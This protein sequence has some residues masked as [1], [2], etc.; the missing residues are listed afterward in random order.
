MKRGLVDGF[1]GNQYLGMIVGLTQEYK[2]MEEMGRV[3]FHDETEPGW[4]LN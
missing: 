4:E 3:L 2:M 1:A